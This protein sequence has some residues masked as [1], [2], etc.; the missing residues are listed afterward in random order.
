MALS[1]D[2]ESI[3]IGTSDG[4]VFI[5]QPRYD[6]KTE[7]SPQITGKISLL[8]FSPNDEFL[9]AYGYISNI[10]E[11]ISTINAMQNPHNIMIWRKTL[12]NR[13]N[14]YNENYSEQ[15]FIHAQ[16]VNNGV[17]LLASP[18]EHLL[19]KNKTT[20]IDNTA[21]SITNPDD[22][23]PIVVALDK[24]APTDPTKTNFAYTYRQQGR[25]P[26]ISTASLEHETNC[27][28]AQEDVQTP[29]YSPICAMNI[30]SNN[31]IYGTEEGSLHII[32]G[33]KIKDLDM[34]T[35]TTK[36]TYIKP[37]QNNC[38]FLVFAQMKK[39]FY[40]MQEQGE[41][42][43]LKNNFQLTNDDVLY[44]H[45]LFCYN[46]QG[47]LR[48]TLQLPNYTKILDATYTH[49]NSLVIIIQAISEQY[50]REF[51][52]LIINNAQCKSMVTTL[53]NQEV[54]GMFIP[55]PHIIGM[56]DLSID[57]NQDTQKAAINVV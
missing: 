22:Q 9:I 57:H 20:T 21:V 48:W 25:A 19:I 24:Q 26:T 30:S 35:H 7:L 4:K 1:H 15:R 54:T 52:Y 47:C 42:L 51:F 14:P 23:T 13:Y 27:M 53:R 11:T 39:Q 40:S 3:A 29:F 18:E 31:I 50:N 43:L 38:D 33:N 16:I 8:A 5:S 41:A 46:A 32:N 44:N 45:V 6:I 36:I 12:N 49:D 34:P 56:H 37:S 2:G 55:A 28:F 17:A 10:Y